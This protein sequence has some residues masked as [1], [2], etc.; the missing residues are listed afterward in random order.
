L[1]GAALNP[2]GVASMACIRYRLNTVFILKFLIL[3]VFMHLR[4]L[5][6]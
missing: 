3:F 4:V 5:R 1:D 2:G 6:G